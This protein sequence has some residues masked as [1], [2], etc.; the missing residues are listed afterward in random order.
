MPRRSAARAKRTLR[1]D[2][3]RPPSGS[4]SGC[5]ATRPTI[6]NRDRRS[7]YRPFAC[8]GF[9]D[10]GGSSPRPTPSDGRCPIGSARTPGRRSAG[11]T[12][13]RTHDL[14]GPFEDEILRI[15]P[16]RGALQCLLLGHRGPP[17]IRGG[18]LRHACGAPGSTRVSR[19]FRRGRRGDWEREGCKFSNMPAHRR[20]FQA[21]TVRKTP[22]TTY[23]RPVASKGERVVLDVAGRA[24][25]VSNPSK[26]YFPEARITKLEVVRYYLA[27][28]AGALRGSGGRPN[29]LVRYANGIHGEF[30]YQKRAPT[31]R[32]DWIEVVDPELP[33]RARR[34]R[35]SCHATRPRSPGW[36]TWVAWSF[37]RIR[38]A[39][40]TSSIPMSC[41]STS[42]RCRVSSGR[43]S[44]A[45]PSRE[46]GSDD[47]GLVGW[48]KTSGSRGIHVNV[49]I[50]RR[51]SFTEVR[52][53]A[54]ALAREVERR[55]PTSPPASGGRRSVTA[56]SST[57]TRT[58]RIERS[59]ARIPYAQTRC[60]GLGARDL[61]RAVRVRTRGL[62]APHHARAFRRD[63][64]SPRG[65]RPVSRLARRAARAVGTT[66]GGG[67]RRRALAAALCEAGWRA[68]VSSSRR[69]EPALAPSNEPRRRRSAGACL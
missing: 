44:S 12:C 28:A 30:F 13:V 66:G 63:R 19:L 37:I 23:T 24:V 58:P 5:S 27:V 35:K 20:A 54:L 17:G 8:G 61:G 50:D 69:A 6:R 52:R 16:E 22:A 64:R 45:S 33:L 47:V 43:S 41:A 25:E 2:D 53:A 21:A 67:P 39:P 40:K 14:L 10:T 1:R 7:P 3:G 55:A 60:P 26:V 59:P 56:C 62:H 51:W 46:A 68:A 65:H 29:V 11:G 32:P 38:F 49:R 9:V 34:R 15:L 4:P 18:G 57:T 42:I 36:R 48:P 31:S